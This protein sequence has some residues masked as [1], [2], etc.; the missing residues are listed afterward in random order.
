MGIMTQIML[1]LSVHVL[2]SKA[3]DGCNV[4]DGGLTLQNLNGSKKALAPENRFNLG[5]NYNSI[6]RS[7]LELGFNMNV[8]ASDD[9]RL[10]HYS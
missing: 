5:I 3:L 4:P 6:L 10:R 1:N 7:G 9:Y 8:K 2:G